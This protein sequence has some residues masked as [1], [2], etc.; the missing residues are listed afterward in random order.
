MVTL[1]PIKA[2]GTRMTVDKVRRVVRT[3]YDD[4]ST[5]VL[6]D[7]TEVTATW[8]N[9][10]AFTR[11][12]IGDGG[13]EITTDDPRFKWIDEGTDGPYPI[14][15]KNAPR[16]KFQTTFQAKTVPGQIM[17]RPGGRSGPWR[18]PQMVMHPGIAPRGWS[19]MIAQRRN[20]LL[21]KKIDDGLRKI[22]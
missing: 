11:T 10:P 4:V 20:K 13:V 2:K 17:S 15:A 19:R 6:S 18:A 14:V 12:I 8:K 3:A 22:V 9:K 1:K 5:D 7:L 21:K 16:L